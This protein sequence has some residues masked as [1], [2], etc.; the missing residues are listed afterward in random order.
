VVARRHVIAA[1]QLTAEEAADLG[2]LLR[3]LTTAMRAELECRAAQSCIDCV[4]SSHC[5][6][7]TVASPR[8]T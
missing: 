5:G 3:V 2:Q 6:P 8:W 4:S 7:V 1:G